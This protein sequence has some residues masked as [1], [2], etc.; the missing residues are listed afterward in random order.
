MILIVIDE[1]VNFFK[2]QILTITDYVFYQMK[3]V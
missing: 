2:F 3:D 1:D